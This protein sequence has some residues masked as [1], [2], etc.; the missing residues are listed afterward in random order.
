MSKEIMDVYGCVR[1]FL[2]LYTKD[3]H[4][5]RACHEHTHHLQHVWSC[6][7][8][9]MRFTYTYHGSHAH[10]SYF[11]RPEKRRKDRQQ[12]ARASPP[13]VYLYIYIY[14]KKRRV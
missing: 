10:I 9:T 2:V 11:F 3:T 5:T 4:T 8:S 6:R 7:A 1:V 14:E 12:V 13:T